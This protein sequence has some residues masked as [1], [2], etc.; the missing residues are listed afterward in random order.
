MRI[1]GH[2]IERPIGPVV[3]QMDGDILDDGHPHVWVG[4]KAKRHNRKANKEHGNYAD[5]LEVG[6]QLAFVH[7]TCVY[8]CAHTHISPEGVRNLVSLHTYFDKIF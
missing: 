8:A 2:L 1:R 5:K 4:F 6:H 3:W 7:S